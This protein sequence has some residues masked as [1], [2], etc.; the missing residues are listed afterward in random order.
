M[1]QFD[2]DMTLQ[3]QFEFFQKEENRIDLPEFLNELN[4]SDV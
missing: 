1:I 3:E 4:I 2:Q